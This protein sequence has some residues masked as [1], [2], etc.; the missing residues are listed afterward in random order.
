MPGL[1]DLHHKTMVE[2]GAEGIELCELIDDGKSSV[3]RVI[4]TEAEVYSD[5]M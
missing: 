4:L 2:S 5:A 3:I 1:M